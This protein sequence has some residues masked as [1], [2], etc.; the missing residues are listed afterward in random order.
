LRRHFESLCR[1]QETED[2]QPILDATGNSREAADL[3]WS[4]L[5]RSGDNLARSDLA[6]LGVDVDGL[7]MSSYRPTQFQFDDLIHLDDDSLRKLLRIIHVPDLEAALSGADA[8]LV[9]RIRSVVQLGDGNGD[10]EEA[11]HRIVAILRGQ[12]ALGQVKF[13]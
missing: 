5:R 3:F 7:S 11:R 9:E 12:A 1:A 13:R 2:L 6:K 10:I 8:K 4:I